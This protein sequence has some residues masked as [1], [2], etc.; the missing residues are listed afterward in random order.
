MFRDTSNKDSGFN[1]LYCKPQKCRYIG[2]IEKLYFDT[3]VFLSSREFHERIDN[4]S[5]CGDNMNL[6]YFI[7]LT[8]L[9]GRLTVSK[10]KTIALLQTL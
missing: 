5:D 3:T 10:K 8:Q 9:F 7:A 4:A 2:W 1:I 6:N